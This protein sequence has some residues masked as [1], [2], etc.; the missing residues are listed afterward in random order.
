V[1]YVVNLRRDEK[2][3]KASAIIKLTA[4]AQVQIIRK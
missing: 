4:D 2:A 3:E 1:D